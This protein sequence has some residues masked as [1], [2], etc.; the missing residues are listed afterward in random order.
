MKSNNI[1]SPWTAI[2]RSGHPRMIR[3]CKLLGLWR[4][5][6]AEVRHIVGRLIENQS[7]DISKVGMSGSICGGCRH[8]ELCHRDHEEYLKSCKEVRNAY[9][10]IRSALKKR[11]NGR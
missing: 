2:F 6:L 9:Y 3:S 4:R 7:I 1:F 10:K 5:P 8:R 11:G